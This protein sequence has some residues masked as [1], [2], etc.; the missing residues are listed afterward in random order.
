[1]TMIDYGATGA[2]RQST[3]TGNPRSYFVKLLEKSPSISDGELIEKIK[4]AALKN[5]DYLDGIVSNW[6]A[7]ERRNLTHVPRPVYRD[8]EERKAVAAEREV[9]VIEL[10]TRIKSHV[11]K[12]VLLEMVMPNGKTL[13]ECTFKDVAR[14]GAKFIGLSKGGKPTEKVG[15]L[16]EAEV[17][18]L[19]RY[20]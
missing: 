1:M 6:V 19:Y 20:A 8:T 18:K 13:A 10:A 5:E 3:R 16:T 9:N 12:M 7:N 11:E 15:K 2:K 14:F 17:Q 4:A